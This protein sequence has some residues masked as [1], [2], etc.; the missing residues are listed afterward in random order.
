[1]HGKFQEAFQIIL[2]LFANL[3]LT[4]GFYLGKFFSLQDGDIWKLLGGKAHCDYDYSYNLHF[5]ILCDIWL[6]VENYFQK[7]LNLLA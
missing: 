3:K 5:L 4:S 2:S 1:M 7:I 6:T